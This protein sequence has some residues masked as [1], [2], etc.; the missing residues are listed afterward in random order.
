[1]RGGRS[2]SVPSLLSWALLGAI[3]LLAVVT[4][5]G[6]TANGFVLDDV[7][8]VAR[9]PSIR[10][11]AHA[12]SWFTSPYA[13]SWSKESANY[14]PVLVTSYALD[15][16]VWGESPAGFHATNL[17][18][19][20]GVVTIVFLLAA[21]LWGQRGAALG[22][23]AWVALHPINAEAVNYVAAR[24]SVLMTF[25]VVGAVL[26]YD[27]SIGAA[28]RARTVRLGGA[29]ALG[30]LALGAKEAAAVLPLLILIWDRARFG[31]TAT[32]TTSVK[33][34]IPFWVLVALWFVVRG[35]IMADTPR[36]APA[37]SAAQA[38]LFGAKIALTALCHSLWPTSLAIDYGWP[39]EIGSGESL[40]LAAGVAV[41]IPAVWGLFR[42][43]RRVG[44]CLA[45]FGVALMP[46]MALPFVTRLTLYQ[47]HRVYLG[48]VG[49]ALI[50][51][52]LLDSAARAFA[53]R[54]TVRVPIAVA[55]VGL[56]V[57]AMSAD[58]VRTAVW[59]DADHLWDDTLAKYPDSALARNERGL[60]LLNDGR[61]DEAEREFQTALRLIPKYAFTHVYLGMT[62]AKRG[63]TERAIDAF[64]TA[65]SFRPR[66][67]EARVRLG[68]TYE[69]QGRSDL[70]LAEYERALGDDPAATSALVRSAGL[71]AAREQWAEAMSRYRRALAIDPQDDEAAVALG[72][73]FLRL[74]RW[75][76]AREIFNAFLA[77]HP[78]SSAARFYIG[79]AHAREGRDDAALPHWLEAVRL[80]P[81]DPEL[82]IELGL[83]YGRRGQW[84]DAIGWYDRALQRDPASFMA[85]VNLALAAERAGDAARALAHYRAFLQTAPHDAGYEGLRIRAQEAIVRLTT[86]TRS[87]AEGGERRRG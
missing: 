7:H 54:R 26:A 65:L 72:A 13:V 47:D 80:N 33:R 84:A 15:E 86:V 4:Y 53:G 71:F 34:S 77:R 48:E 52:R 68:M 9:N 49:I 35:A 61:L 37:G 10:S 17:L 58:R 87:P 82:L 21:R 59:A 73:L 2:P 51:G 62:Y 56:I 43:D 60:R 1:M 74:E 3:L 69:Q 85:H 11:W 8:T 45:W 66:F 39:V 27:A 57:A 67:T 16:A 81:D 76:E 44:W 28:G 55:L 12:A 14:R 24:S 42:V 19:H 29:L 64:N 18:L 23:A 75:P 22:A 70:A 46:L 25:G 40:V 63:D 41:V 78:D 79:M 6:V 31:E 30:G 38:V 36:A 83:L 50:A 20:L 5:R 32:W